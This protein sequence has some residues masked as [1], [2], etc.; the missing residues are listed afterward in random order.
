[1]NHLAASCGELPLV[2]TS[3]DQPL[4]P[5]DHSERVPPPSLA[6]LSGAIE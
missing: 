5:L 3:R 4:E 6:G 1:M 2:P